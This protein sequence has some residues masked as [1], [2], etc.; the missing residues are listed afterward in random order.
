MTISKEYPCA[1]E[2]YT[3]GRKGKIEYIVIHYTGGTGSA[4]A[5]VR[6]YSGSPDRKASAH[7][8]VGHKSE[9]AAIY[10]SVAPENT[11][12]HCGAK[13]YKHPS[14]RNSNSIG[15]EMCCHNSNGELSAAS[16]GWYFDGETENQAAALTRELMKVYK[17]P[18][19]HVV[20]HFDVTG[21]VCPAPFVKNGG[22]WT[23]FIQKISEKGD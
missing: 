3:A 2:N 17:I 10:Q 11:A 22:A 18:A 23:S 5:N 21:K 9:G 1:L 12:W 7:F 20:R 15:I 14:C 6:Y 19:D 8:F 13:T 16:E 4:L